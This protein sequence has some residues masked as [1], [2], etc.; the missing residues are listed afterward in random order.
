[1]QRILRLNTFTVALLALL[2]SCTLQVRAE[3]RSHDKFSLSSKFAEAFEEPEQGLPRPSHITRAQLMMVSAM[4]A[5]EQQYIPE[6][7]HH[8]KRVAK[9]KRFKSWSSFSSIRLL[10]RE[11]PLYLQRVPAP[12]NYSTPFFLSHLHH[13]LFRLTLF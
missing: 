7:D 3:G 13:F 4:S 12:P 11:L 5:A 2:L 10:S 1:M 8:K 6:T 9:K